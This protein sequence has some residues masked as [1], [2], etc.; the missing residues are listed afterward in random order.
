MQTASTALSKVPFG[1]YAQIGFQIGTILDVQPFPKAR[2]PSYKVTAEF[3]K[4]ITTSAQLPPNYPD[5][6]TLLG[7]QVV[8]VINLPQRRIAGFLSQF[9]V[10]GF[11]DAEHHVH[12]LNT[13]GRQVPNGQA[14]DMHEKAPISIEYEI[15]QK[16]DI[17]A[18]TV[19]NMTRCA[20]DAVTPSEV[21]Y[22]ATVDVGPLG[23]RKV[24]IVD[25]D[26]RIFDELQDSGSNQIAVIVNI[27]QECVTD[28]DNTFVL[29]FKDSNG[30]KIPLGIDKPVENGV[31]LF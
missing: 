29:T 11:P 10:V 20:P 24:S 12:L 30:K 27:A 3:E 8:G 15:F 2:N 1:V 26:E 19:L 5:P 22:I 6:Q 4:A 14:L 16:A 28:G 23:E 18:A 13:R 31:Q 17:R 25:T 21:S 7:R 9:L